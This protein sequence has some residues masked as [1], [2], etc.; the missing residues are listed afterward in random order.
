[1]RQFNIKCYVLQLSIDLFLFKE[2]GDGVWA[3]LYFRSPS[4]YYPYCWDSENSYTIIP[5]E[6][7]GSIESPIQCVLIRICTLPPGDIEN[8][9]E[10]NRQRCKLCIRNK[11]IDLTFCLCLLRAVLFT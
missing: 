11:Q 7:L 10:N 8:D 5:K 9:K 4:N 6:K 3:E 1:M 2:V